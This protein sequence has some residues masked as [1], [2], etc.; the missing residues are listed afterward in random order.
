MFELDYSSGHNMERPDGLSTTPS[1]NN[2]EWGGKQRKMRDTILTISNMGTI[3]HI[4]SLNIGDT[5]SMIFLPTDLPPNFNPDVPQ[6]DVMKEGED[7]T[8][9]LNKV[10]IKEK[11]GAMGYNTDGNIKVLKQRA[12]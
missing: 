6:Y 12:T 9:K 8:R 1:V 2:M 11:L 10:E 7:V 4:R 3:T 5:K